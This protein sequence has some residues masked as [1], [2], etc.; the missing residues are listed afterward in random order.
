MA[1]VTSIANGAWNADAAT[2]WD[3]GTIPGPADDAVIDG[4]AVTLDINPTCNSVEITGGSLTLTAFRVL[5]G[6]FELNGGEIDDGGFAFL[7]GGDIIITDGTLTSSGAWFQT[8]DGNV[9]NAAAGTKFNKIVLGVGVTSALTNHVHTAALELGS[10]AIIGGARWLYVHAA[11]ASFYADAGVSPVTT[12][13]MIW[14]LADNLSVAGAT[15]SGMQSGLMIGPTIN[16]KTVTMTGPLDLGAYDIT[17]VFGTAGLITL[18]MGNQPLTCWNAYVGLAGQNTRY[19]RIEFGNGIHAI[20]GDLGVAEAPAAA[21]GDQIDMG[22]CRMTLGGAFD[23]EADANKVTVTNT[24]SHIQGG[25]VANVDN[26]SAENIHCQGTVD[27]GGNT[28]VDFDVH[29]PSGTMML[30]GAGE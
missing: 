12:G 26:D 7:I 24:A 6:D 20:G 1:V 13:G 3:S 9:A 14:Y 16:D 21:D 22:S 28:N 11:A 10:T 29:P 15:L 4:E 5:T 23:G 2:V 25:T 18:A 19:G 17:A 8:E 30:V 27:G